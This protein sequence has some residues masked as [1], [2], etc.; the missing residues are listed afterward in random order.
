[1]NS[2][3]DANFQVAL[4]DH[5]GKQFNSTGYVF[6]PVP[7]VFE[8]LV[9]AVSHPPAISGEYGF[10]ILFFQ[11]GPDDQPHLATSRGKCRKAL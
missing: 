5:P 10:H 2:K 11:V 9:Q 4:G 1:M 6:R 3:G 7:G 8:L